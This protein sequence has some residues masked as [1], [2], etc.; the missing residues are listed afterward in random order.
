M[1]HRIPAACACLPASSP[2]L[3]ALS[4]LS[5]ATEWLHGAAWRLSD[6]LL[7]LT[8]AGAANGVSLRCVGLCLA[9][10]NEHNMYPSL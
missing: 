3:T 5:A 1:Q 6:S 4:G 8:R 2:L 9:L 7:A 10:F